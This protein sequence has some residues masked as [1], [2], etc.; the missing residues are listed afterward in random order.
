MCMS[1]VL[2]YVF[3][4]SGTHGGQK[5]ASG[6]LELDLQIVVNHLVGAG[7]QTLVLYKSCKC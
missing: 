1:G 2:A 5:A 6:L 3:H 4:V 7:N